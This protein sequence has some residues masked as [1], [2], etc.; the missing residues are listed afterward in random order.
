MYEPGELQSVAL[1]ELAQELM[2]A[3]FS[4]RPPRRADPGFAVLLGERDRLDRLPFS[5]AAHVFQTQL[6]WSCV[7]QPVDASDLAPFSWTSRALA[8]YVHK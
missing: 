3:T 4:K 6:V 5:R 8:F 7:N 1:R 2:A